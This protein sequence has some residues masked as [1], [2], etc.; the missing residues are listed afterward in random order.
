MHLHSQVVVK[1]VKSKP[2]EPV[3]IVVKNNDETNQDKE[4]CCDCGD[5][6]SDNNNIETT[7]EAVVEKN[8]IVK[9]TVVEKNGN[10]DVIETP[11]NNAVL[12]NYALNLTQV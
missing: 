5:D 1:Y 9:E 8:P 6:N 7:I 4:M 3:K 2:N 11:F 12:D 10:V